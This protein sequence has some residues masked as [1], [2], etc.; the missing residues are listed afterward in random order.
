MI[1]TDE[2][3]IEKAAKMKAL[4]YSPYSN[5]KVGAAILSKVG[6]V[7]TGMNIENAS[8]SAACC[9]E[10]V[11]IYKAM[12]EGES[13]FIKIA[14]ISDSEDITLPCGVC[15]QV[16]SEICPEIIILCAN[17]DGK[18]KEF[19][20]KDLLPHAFELKKELI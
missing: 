4:S 11:A 12:S 14:I 17:K 16:M 3:L 18:Y 13:D 10:R 15:L 2:E 19:L 8:Y 7:F 5:F 1:F 20:I 9:A 6:K